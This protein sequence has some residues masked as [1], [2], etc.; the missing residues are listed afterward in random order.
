MVQGR[1]LT[2]KGLEKL[3]LELLSFDLEEVKDDFFGILRNHNASLKHLLL[4]RN[5]ISNALMEE[6]CN[7]I[8]ELNVIETLDLTHLKEANKIDWQKYLSSIALLSV[9]RPGK[10]VRVILSDY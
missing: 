4:G 1:F 9:N 7:E 8:K 2:Y 10:P 6:M 5:K 3:G